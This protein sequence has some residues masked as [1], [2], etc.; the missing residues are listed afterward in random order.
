MF[1]QSRRLAAALLASSALAGLAALPAPA[2]AQSSNAGATASTNDDTGSVV[3][4]TGTR[5]PGRTAIESPVPVDVISADEI[6][7]V[8]A[9]G[10]LGAALQIVAPSFNFSRQ[11]NS[12]STDVVRMGQLRGMNPDQ[13]LVLVNGRRRHT[14]SVVSLDAK[15][16][17][18]TT[19]VD[20][21]SIPV[22]AIER[23]EVLRDG[24]GAQYGSDAVAGVINVILK[25]GTGP[26]TLDASYG[27]HVTD[28]E[29]TGREITDG[30]TATLAISS[31]IALGDTGY[32]RFGADYRD[33]TAT[34]RSAP[35]NIF[36]F[37]FGVEPDSPLNQQFAGVP[38]TYRAGDPSVTD[39]NVWANGEIAVGEAT[40]YGTVTFNQREG[41]G[42]A[43]Y[44]YPDGSAGVPALYPR[45]YRPITT[46]DN[47]DFGLI[48]GLRRQVGAWE[49]DAGINYG[50][51]TFDYGVTNSAN[52]SL[53]AASPTS[54]RSASYESS[55]FAIN[56][57]ATREIAWGNLA[58]GAEV[59]SEAYETIAG[60][61]ASYQAG[62]LAA[63]GRRIG[64]QAGPGLSAADATSTDRTVVA[65]Y[66][67]A[68]LEPIED[69]LALDIAG[70]Y[71]SY[72]DVGEALAGKIS[73]RLN[74]TDAF[75]LRASASNSFRAPALSQTAF[76][77]TTTTLGSGGALV[78]V[79]TVA[80]GSAIGRALGA[81]ELE[82]ETSTN[83]SVGF[84]AAL[85]SFTLTL[86]AFKVDVDDRIIVTERNFGYAGLIQTRTGIANV[87]DVA[88][89]TNGVDTS[90]EGLD[91]VATWRTQLLGG[92]L[93]LTGAYNRSITEVE[94]V[95]RAPSFVTGFQVLGVE[96]RNTI[97]DAAPQDRITGSATWSNDSWTLTSRVTRHGETTRVFN[98]GGG[99]EPTQTYGAK[100][101]LDLEAE[102][103]ITPAI[104][105]AIGGN[106]VLDEYPDRS[107]DDISYFSAFPYDVLSPIGFNGAYWYG[108]TRITF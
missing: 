71:E 1:M 41:Q 31:G 24:A 16:G 47:T 77:F 19:P 48:A 107:I 92:D 78:D 108:R 88:V 25:D 95:R 45:G 46:N 69:R 86:D 29:P 34:A 81:P 9:Y 60:D 22:S 28:F 27:A 100:T 20:F 23:I 32:L 53:G 3:V 70:R 2:L 66:A 61:L 68:G 30:H 104:A 101:Q 62:P 79:R 57:D 37:I 76:Q 6:A 11:S 40:L 87:T 18:G 15:I 94:R 91:L 105:V 82:P 43:F 73:G 98:F 7:R 49:V 97:E 93:S 8:G 75:A 59:R 65:L 44:R 102:W 12:S 84:T 39:L 17:R 74:L 64:A 67:E 72:S 51:N 55:L 13:V 83:F 63:S 5:T 56:V 90:T 38:G 99:F 96:E 33:R 35:I 54:F 50:R 52:P 42:A 36:A 21:N 14:T 10:E 26:T 58:V 85:G 80:P 89:F 103:Q 106:N 4:V